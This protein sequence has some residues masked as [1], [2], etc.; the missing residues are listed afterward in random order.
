VPAAAGG[1]CDWGACDWRRM[2]DRWPVCFGRTI[3]AAN[4]ADGGDGP[5]G[6]FEGGGLVPA[7]F[8]GRHFRQEIKLAR[9]K[10]GSGQAP[11]GARW[12]GY[13]VPIHLERNPIPSA[14]PTARPRA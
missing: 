1:A 8:R 6:L 10:P 9:S 7:L 11:C 4:D 14:K 5:G 3:A 13:I 12:A 2:F